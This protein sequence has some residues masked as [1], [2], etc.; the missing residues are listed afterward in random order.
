VAFISKRAAEH[1]PLKT[2]GASAADDGVKSSREPHELLIYDDVRLRPGTRG[3]CAPL[4]DE[5]VPPTLRIEPAAVFAVED[6]RGG[7]IE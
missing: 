1:G 3:T 5:Q 7:D 6:A 4:F 2:H